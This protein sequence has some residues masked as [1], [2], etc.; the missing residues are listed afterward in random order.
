MIKINMLNY[1]HEDSRRFNWY[2]VTENLQIIEYLG[3]SNK[4]SPR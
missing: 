4:L 3:I 1:F 2:C